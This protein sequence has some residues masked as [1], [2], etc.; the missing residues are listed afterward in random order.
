MRAC[1]MGLSLEG[2]VVLREM[3]G[4]QYRM[5][6]ESLSEASHHRET[7]RDSV[8]TLATPYGKLEWRYSAKQPGR[9]LDRRQPQRPLST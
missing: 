2:F 8:V 5:P 1:L 6:H 4:C 9:P 7:A 3:P